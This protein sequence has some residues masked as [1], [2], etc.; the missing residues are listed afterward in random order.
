MSKAR[1]EIPEKIRPYIKAECCDDFPIEKYYKTPQVD[2]I[3]S[4]IED[5][6]RV[7]SEMQKMGLSYMNSTLLYSVPG[8][9]K[10]TLGRYIAYVMDKDFI[11]IDFAKLFDGVFGKTTGIISDVFEFARTADC[12]FMMDEI[13]CIS[14]KRGTEGVATGGEIGR[15]TTVIMQQLDNYR[16]LG[17]DCI[18]IG[19]TNKREIMDEALF[20]R[21]SVAVEFKTLTNQE[22][23]EYIKLYLNNVNYTQANGKKG[24][25]YDVANIKEYCSRNSAIRQRNVESDM[26]RCIVQWIK[27]GKTRFFLEHI[28]EDR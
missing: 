10:T 14:Q 8:T 1:I 11:Y 19:A 17:T 20:S 3:I 22:K 24:I 26:N 5:T 18:V 15:I 28:R 6:R 23:E 4:S 16:R 2:Q 25:P 27:S 9:G 21:F 13:D 12:I 7:S